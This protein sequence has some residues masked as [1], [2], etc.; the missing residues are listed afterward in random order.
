MSVI[1]K[2]YIKDTCYQEWERAVKLYE[3]IGKKPAITLQK[4]E[5][6]K[7][8]PLGTAS[9]KGVI[10]ITANFLQTQMFDDLLDT[11]RH[12]ICHLLASVQNRH[13]RVW[14]EACKLV[15]CTP[16][17][18]SKLMSDETY[19]RNTYKYKLIAV[20]R[21]GEEIHAGRNKRTK[22]YLEYVPYSRGIKGLGAIAYFK[23]VDVKTGEEFVSKNP[24]LFSN[25]S[26]GLKNPRYNYKL[27]CQLASGEVILAGF[28]NRRDPN[29]L[30]A[31]PGK[32]NIKGKPVEKFIYE[33]IA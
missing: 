8:S 14:R 24:S 9:S 22:R 27:Y 2:Q 3:G 33:L 21:K 31:P 6:K 12:E 7:I 15:G 13:N 11:I 1:T 26:S 18:S 30:N 25:E 19:I 32:Y 29:Y 4:V 17:A 28:R 20:N 10:T 16:R 23:Y 5:V